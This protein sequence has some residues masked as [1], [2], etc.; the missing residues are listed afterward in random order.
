MGLLCDLAKFL[1]LSELV[2]SSLQEYY[3]NGFVRLLVGPTRAT[4]AAQHQSSVKGSCECVTVVI[5]V[6]G[7]TCAGPQP[8]LITMIFP[9]YGGSYVCCIAKL[10][11]ASCVIVKQM[12]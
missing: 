3:N 1:R 2:F 12:C 9:E 8:V 11:P 4:W 7:V 5:S 6:R 10:I